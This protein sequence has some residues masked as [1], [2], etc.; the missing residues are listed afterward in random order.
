MADINIYGVLHNATPD[1]TIA[2]ADQIKDETQNKDQ[3]A[4]NQEVKNKLDGIKSPKVLLCGSIMGINSWEYGTDLKDTVFAGITWDDIMAADVV[5]FGKKTE[6]NYNYIAPIH[7]EAH[8]N[9]GVMCLPDPIDGQQIFVNLGNGFGDNR[10]FTVGDITKK[11]LITEDEKSKIGEKELIWD[12]KFYYIFNLTTESSAQDI[13]EAFPT[14]LKQ[15][16]QDD[17]YLDYLTQHV[18]TDLNGSDIV[19]IL[20]NGSENTFDFTVIHGSVVKGVRIKFSD[21]NYD[22]STVTV[23]KAFSVDI[24]ELSGGGS[25]PSG[26]Y[27]VDIQKWGHGGSSYLPPSDLPGNGDYLYVKYSD[28]TGTWITYQDLLHFNKGMAKSSSNESELSVHVPNTERHL[29]SETTGLT[30]KEID[31]QIY[32]FNASSQ[33]TVSLSPKSIQNK[34]YKWND[35]VTALNITLD[36]D[37]LDETGNMLLE[38]MFEF[39]SGDTPTVLTITPEPNWIGSHEVEANKTYQVSIVNGIG[40]MVGFDTPTEEITL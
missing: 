34:Y 38:Y 1:N 29:Q 21:S 2:R 40:V 7:I 13:E 22:F 8:N 23:E 9:Y 6:D 24:A 35:K 33:T 14:G 19:N 27:V 12:E 10:D 18:F 4:I 36:E 25:T 15:A 31:T 11:V 20:F 26:K 28:G 39:E 30:T 3:A 17:N 16:I 37:T 32:T 5:L